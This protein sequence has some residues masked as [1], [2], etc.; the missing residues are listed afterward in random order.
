MGREV[1]DVP[2]TD[3]PPERPPSFGSELAPPA[4]PED[5]DVEAAGVELLSFFFLLAPKHPRFSNVT[6]KTRI[7]IVLYIYKIIQNV[8]TFGRWRRCDPRLH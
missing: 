2:D 4:S 6:K 8:L 1:R 3:P 5:A 7:K